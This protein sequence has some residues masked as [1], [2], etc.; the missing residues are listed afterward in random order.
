[1][2]GHDFRLRTDKQTLGKAPDKK[3]FVDC[4]AGIAVRLFILSKDDDWKGT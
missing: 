3:I 2:S 1:V 4:V